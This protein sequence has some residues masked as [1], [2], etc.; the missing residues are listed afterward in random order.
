MFRAA[1]IILAKDTRLRVRDRS[2]WIFA[3]VVPLALTFVF[4]SLLRDT[5]DFHLHA[6]L[7]QADQGELAMAFATG[8]VAAVDA[9]G[10][11]PVSRFEAE[12]AAGGAFGTGRT[13]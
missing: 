8:V 9:E 6:G 1:L 5:E 13:G 2:V 10:F 11:A 4:S 12:E 7:V 3:F